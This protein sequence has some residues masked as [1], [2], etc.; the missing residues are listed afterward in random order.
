MGPSYKIE[1]A[2]NQQNS[3]SL[4]TVE[5][6]VSSSTSLENKTNSGQSTKQSSANHSPFTLHTESGVNSYF[7]GVSSSSYAQQNKGSLRHSHQ[8]KPPTIVYSGSN[9]IY[10]KA[11]QTSAQHLKSNTDNESGYSTPISNITKK[12]VYEVIV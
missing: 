11:Y 5:S 8:T 4:A 6:D 1:Y 9:N 12:L 7:T 3:S 2:Q 10:V